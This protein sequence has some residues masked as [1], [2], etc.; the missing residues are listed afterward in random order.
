M[1]IL[2][3]IFCLVKNSRWHEAL[4]ISSGEDHSSTPEEGY[5]YCLVFTNALPHEELVGTY[6]YKT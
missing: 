5:L 6:H 3:V 4:A 1:K 2:G